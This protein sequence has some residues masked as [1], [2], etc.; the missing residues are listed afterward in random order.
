MIKTLTM[1]ATCLIAA[2]SLAVLVVWCL[3]RLRKIEDARWGELRKRGH[4][5]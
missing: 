3:R 1:L 4:W 5:G 2:G